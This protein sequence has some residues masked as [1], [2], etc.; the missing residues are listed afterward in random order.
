MNRWIL[1]LIVAFVLLIGLAVLSSGIWFPGVSQRQTAK[2][3]VTDSKFG[4]RA[5]SKAIWH[6]PDILGDIASLTND[7]SALDYYQAAIL[8][9]LLMDID[10]SDYIE[11]A[12]E[13]Y[14]QGTLSARLV[15]AL[16]LAKNH[17]H[18]DDMGSFLKRV[19]LREYPGLN[20]DLMRV[21]DY[22]SE[23]AMGAL[24]YLNND[25]SLDVLKQVINQRKVPYQRHKAALAALATLNDR[26]AIDFIREAM[27]DRTFYAVLP[28]Y[29]ALVAL[30]DT[31]ARDYAQKRVAMRL[32]DGD[33]RFLIERLND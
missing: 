28:A 33:E 32:S 7:Y 14:Q 17:I 31:Q 8:T 3:L 11:H 26:R 1:V 13:L 16:I 23:M 22:W 27:L 6:G 21:R 2:I 5:Y 18:V 29:D 25:E 30:G 9:R 15:G 24:G 12:R 4:S 20:S 19:I 10:S